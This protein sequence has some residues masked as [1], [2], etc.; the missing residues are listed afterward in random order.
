MC[1]QLRFSNLIQA[2]RPLSVV[3]LALSNCASDGLAGESTSVA[4]GWFYVRSDSA[5]LQIHN[6]GDDSVELIVVEIQ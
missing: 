5:F 2:K 1:I 4:H 3:L 6:K